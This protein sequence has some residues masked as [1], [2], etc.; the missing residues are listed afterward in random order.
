[1]T[2]TDLQLQDISH[3]LRR[4]LSAFITGDEQPPVD[5]KLDWRTLQEVVR[6]RNLGALFSFCHDHTPLPPPVVQEWRRMKM[7]TT[8][9]NLAKLK[10]TTDLTALAEKAGIRA[11]A[12]RGIVLAHWLYPDPAMRPMHDIDLLV[13]PADKEKFHGAMLAAGHTPTDY[14]RSQYVYMI[15]KV[16]VEVH[17]QLLSNKRYRE[18]MDSDLLVSSAAR[19]DTTSGPINRLTDTWEIIGLVVHAFTHHNL[20]QLFSLIDIGLYLRNKEVDWQEIARLSEEMGIARMMHLTFAF[21]NHLFGLGV[22]A[23]VL[24]YFS[25]ESKNAA[26]YFQAY[27]DQTLARITLSTHLAV[28]QSQFYVAETYG[29]KSREFLRLFS[30]KERRFLLELMTAHFFNTKQRLKA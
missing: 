24:D 21:I 7:A 26:P 15:N 16:T 1:M 11:V 25:P 9:G 10:I 12:M 20:S 8:L 3:F 14:F 17:W 4:T 5:A 13:R 2:A 28:K 29:N 23:K 18:R 27:L 22:E 6:T 19:V 30:S